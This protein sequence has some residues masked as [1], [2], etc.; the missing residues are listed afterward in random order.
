MQLDHVPLKSDMSQKR[1]EPYHVQLSDC[2]V[3]SWWRKWWSSWRFTAFLEGLR[4]C[5][6]WILIGRAQSIFDREDS[7]SYGRTTSVSPLPPL[8]NTLQNLLPVLPLLTT[9]IGNSNF[10]F[11]YCMESNQSER[12]KGSEKN[13][14]YS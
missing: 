14:N 11:N 3:S 5:I 4:P 1:L 7:H 6:N 13:R 2:V 8:C 9:L 10:R 12:I